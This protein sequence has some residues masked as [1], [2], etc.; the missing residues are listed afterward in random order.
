MLGCPPTRAVKPP[1]VP[2]FTMG[3]QVRPEEGIGPFVWVPAPGWLRAGGGDH[4]Q[5]TESLMMFSGSFIIV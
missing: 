2:A 1:T 3:I 5:L 4:P